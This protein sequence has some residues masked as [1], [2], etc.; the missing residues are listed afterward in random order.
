VARGGRWGGGMWGGGIVEYE[1][2]YEN[3]SFSYVIVDVFSH[4]HVG[5]CCRS[6]L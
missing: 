1:M 6:L 2:I 3:P 5:L 4:R